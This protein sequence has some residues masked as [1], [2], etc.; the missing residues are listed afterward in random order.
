MKR[1]AKKHG[2]DSFQDRKKNEG[3]EQ[4]IIATLPEDLFKLNIDVYF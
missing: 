2:D 1:S 3:V 4:C